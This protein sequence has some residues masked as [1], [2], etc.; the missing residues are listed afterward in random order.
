MTK[1]FEL[2]IEKCG[3][4]IYPEE[5]DWEALEFIDNTLDAAAEMVAFLSFHFMY[6]SA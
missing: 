6:S 1:S 3:T 4:S 2:V 5:F